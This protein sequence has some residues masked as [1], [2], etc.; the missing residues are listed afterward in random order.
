MKM[1]TTR[2]LERLLE[3]YGNGDIDRRKF[4]GLAAAAAAAAGVST[5][6]TGRALAAVSE[7]RF[8]GW[9]G[10]VQ[11][12]LHK[13]AFE[14]YSKKTGLKVVEGTFGDEIEVLTKVKASNPGDY[15]VIHSSGVDWY[16]RYLDL[17]F[18][19]ELDESKIPNLKLVMTRV[20]RPLPQVDA[21][22]PVG[23]A[24]RL[25]HH[26][27][28]LQH[29]GTSSKEEAVG[30]GVNLLLKK[31]LKGKIG[32]L[33]EMQTR[34]W[35]G[36]LQT[37][38]NPNDVKDIDAVWA[39]ARERRELVV[40][41]WGSGAELI[42]LL[43]KE[44]IIVTRR[45]V[46]PRRRAAAGRLPHRLLRPAGGLAWLEGLLVLKGSARLAECEQLLNFCSSRPSRSRSPKGRTTRPRST[47]PRCRSPTR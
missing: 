16:K 1:S 9:G 2:R 40:K 46:G 27:H 32:A 37:G 34:V 3:R 33:N 19:T 6:W 20:D 12:A 24:L 10:V 15:Q 35:Y 26:R 28:R 44:E 36:A 4:L 14:P 22:C 30:L 31:E 45:L 41:Y 11:E 7:V 17:G 21:E 8:D 25:R 13:N 38:Q 18:T 29:E 47:R 5:R 39:K 43:S 42:D 23:R